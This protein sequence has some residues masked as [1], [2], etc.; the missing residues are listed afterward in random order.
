MHVMYVFFKVSIHVQQ[1]TQLKHYAAC[2]QHGR[3]ETT[4]WRQTAEK[5]ENKRQRDAKMNWNSWQP[6]NRK[7]KNLSNFRKQT[8]IQVYKYIQHCL[9]KIYRS[10]KRKKRETEMKYGWGKLKKRNAGTE[11]YWS[12]RELQKLN[13][14][15]KNGSG[16]AKREMRKRNAKMI[17]E[18]R[19]WMKKNMQNTDIKEKDSLHT[20]E[21]MKISWKLW[22][23]K[24]NTNISLTIFYIFILLR[25]KTFI[26]TNNKAE[27]AFYVNEEGLRKIKE[28]QSKSLDEKYRN[29][30]KPV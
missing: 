9:S 7:Q 30:Q 1:T 11:D 3:G 28:E 25:I 19:E 27:T 5:C 18:R 15:E 22:R 17:Y 23:I 24:I 14:R 16:N 13:A 10:W 12:R 6:R 2:L 21:S 20:A 29:R 26:S 8:F 4:D